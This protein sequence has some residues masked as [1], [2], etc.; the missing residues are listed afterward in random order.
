MAA[1]TQPPESAPGDA[2]HG[3]VPLIGKLTLIG[4]G[5]IG[6]SFA[7]GLRAAGAVR[8]V[9]GFDSVADALALAQE[10]GVIDAPATD[11]ETAVADADLVLIAIPVGQMR[12]VLQRILPVLPPAALITDAGS[13]KQDVVRV[14]SEVCGAALNRFV[15]G[16]PIAGSERSGPGAARADLFHDRRVVLT[17]LNETDADAIRR[18]AAAWQACGA[19][20]QRMNAATHDRIFAAVSHLP[21]LLSFALVE[22]LATRNDAEEF[23]RYAAGGFRDFTRIAGSSPEMWRDVSLAN[24]DALLSEL[25]TYQTQLAELHRLVENRDAGGLEAMFARARAARAAWLAGE[26]VGK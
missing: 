7:L 12:A 16:H 24:R 13:T 21:H 5:L 26:P 14:A 20:V 9:V 17:P 22:E 1:L 10:L 18:V 23:F 15:P 11:P 3:A 4:V 8:Q 19:S 2:V 6:G 25:E